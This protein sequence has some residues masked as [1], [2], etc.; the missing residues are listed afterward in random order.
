MDRAFNLT[1]IG[2]TGFHLILAKTAQRAKNAHYQLILTPNPK[3]NPSNPPDPSA[4]S[5]HK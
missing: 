3:S 4:D 5:H 1:K 2:Y